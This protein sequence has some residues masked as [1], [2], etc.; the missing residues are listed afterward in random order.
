MLTADG[1]LRI[2]PM[3]FSGRCRNAAIVALCAAMCVAAPVR[4]ATTPAQSSVLSP[5]TVNALPAPRDVRLNQA[6]ADVL[7]AQILLDRAH[8][9]PGEIDAVY[10]SNMRRALVGFQQRHGLA[11]TGTLDAATWAA[12]NRDAAPVL[13]EYE[14]AAQD[15]AGP[16]TA[17]PEDMMDKAALPALAYTSPLEALA[18]RFHAS[19]T[20]LATLNPGVDFARAGTRIVVPAVAA[21]ALPKA[22]QLV[23]DESDS[24]VALVDASGATYA[25]FPATTGSEHDPLPIG[26][27]KVNGVQRDPKFHYN[28]ELFWDADPGHAK[29][30]IEAGPN[31]PVGVVW[32]DLSK[33]HYGIHG[34]PE[35][36]TI[37]KTQS[38]G[39]IRLTNWSA[40]AV[41]DAVSPGTPAILRE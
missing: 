26:E 35:P 23:V 24:V 21:D 39:C 17:I 16:F 19:P 5:E 27:W 13:V 3:T 25:Q 15:V 37:G 32:I 20:L 10:G 2:T 7:R 9:S 1:R 30:T 6:G 14:I 36:A 31:N 4:A 40:A 29:A 34:T 41:A 18:E 8:F 38:H 28:P 12:L 22:A 33:E 11:A